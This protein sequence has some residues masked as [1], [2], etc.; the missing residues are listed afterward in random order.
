MKLFRASRGLYPNYV[1][2]RPGR[3]K[4]IMKDPYLNNQYNDLVEF[5]WLDKKK[6]MFTTKKPHLM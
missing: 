5:W 3:H 6:H 4:T 2:G 1:G